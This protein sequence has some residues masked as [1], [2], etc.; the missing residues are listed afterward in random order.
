MLLTQI[1][2]LG[3]TD[4]SES[5]RDTLNYKEDMKDLWTIPNSQ[6]V[7]RTAESLTPC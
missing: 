5:G 2:L 1:W 6:L 7:K 3:A 4:E